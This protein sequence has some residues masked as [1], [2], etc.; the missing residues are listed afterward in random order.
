MIL[1]Q[2]YIQGRSVKELQ[3]ELSD[4]GWLYVEKCRRNSPDMGKRYMK[5]SDIRSKQKQLLVCI[6]PHKTKRGY[7]YVIDFA[8][9]ILGPPIQIVP[10]NLEL[11]TRKYLNGHAIFQ[12]EFESFI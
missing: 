10:A 6:Y 4:R 11:Q 9:L 7:Y 12:P 1:P 2:Y 3:E 8:Y 5:T